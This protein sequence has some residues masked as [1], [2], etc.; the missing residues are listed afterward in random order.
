MVAAFSASR[1]LR[2]FSL[3][4]KMATDLA[5]FTSFCLRRDFLAANSAAEKQ[6]RIEES[7][8]KMLFHSSL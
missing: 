3:S 1:C 7:V 8:G 6:E 5:L 2:S 4:E